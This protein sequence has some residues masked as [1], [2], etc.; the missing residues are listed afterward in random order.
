[1]CLL[2][3]PTRAS[4]FWSPDSKPGIRPALPPRPGVTFWSYCLALPWML[5]GARPAQI[6]QTRYSQFDSLLPPG[7]LPPPAPTLTTLHCLSCPAAPLG[8]F[9]FALATCLYMTSQAGLTEASTQVGM[10]ASRRAGLL[11]APALIRLGL[12]PARHQPPPAPAAPPLPTVPDLPPGN[13]GHVTGGMWLMHLMDC[14]WLFPC[15]LY[16]M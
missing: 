4:T 11:C 12:L 1:M 8:F 7:L 2:T 10:P 3:S 15:V 6:C 14:I 5:W 16:C 9:A 13:A